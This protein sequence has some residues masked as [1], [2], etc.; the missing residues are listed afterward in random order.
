MCNRRSDEVC[1]TTP[2]RV[3]GRLG[4]RHGCSRLSSGPAQGATRARL[5]WCVLTCHLRLTCEFFPR[6]AAQ[7][8]LLVLL[9]GNH[10][11][12]RALVTRL[13]TGLLCRMGSTVVP[14]HT[15]QIE[16]HG[17]HCRVVLT[18]DPKHMNRNSL[19]NSAQGP[20]RWISPEI[21][22]PSGLTP[23]VLRSHAGW[24]AH[25]PR[26]HSGWT[27]PVPWTPSE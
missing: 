9:L 4:C 5:A 22:T 18:V 24:T 13:N 12:K 10:A 2:A 20:L 6:F 23:P 3:M 17:C 11:M 8:V 7:R 14:K 21:G 26:T 25:A 15:D 1:P 16:S 27:A 19:L